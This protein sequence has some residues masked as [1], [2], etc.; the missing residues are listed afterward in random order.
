VSPDDAR[1]SGEERQSR[2]DFSGAAEAFESGG[3]FYEAAL[4]FERCDAPARCFENLLRVVPGHPRYRDACVR[5]VKLA[6]ARGPLSLGFENLVAA[7]VKSG[8]E[9][10]AEVEAFLGLAQLY[11][12]EGFTENAIEALQRISAREPGHELARRQLE[13]LRVAPPPLPELP[14]PPSP[15]RERVDTPYG[16]F[17]PLEEH[18]STPFRVGATVAGRYQ[19]EERIGAGG[20][21]VVFRARDLQLHDQVALK[22]FKQAAL[23]AES[24]ARLRRELSL[25]RLLVH[26]NVVQLYAIGL[27]FG[28][29]YVTLELLTGSDL[30]DRM[31]GEALPLGEGLDYLVQACAGLAAAHDVGIVHRDVKPENCFITRD[32][33]VKLMDF[34][35]AKA[36]D[37]SGLTAT[38]MV[39]GTPAYMA[40]EQVLNFSSVTAAA[41]QY[42]LG[43]VAYEMFTA[44]RPFR[45]PEPV[46]LMMLHTTEP[47]PP[48]RGVNPALPLEL[49]QIILRCLAKDPKQRFAS[50]RELQR[51]LELLRSRL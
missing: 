41:D 11:E 44:T 10:P 20:M 37:V 19:L 33:R 22:V 51:E 24:D 31:R 36:R 29:R 15:A 8:P 43:V 45:H 40:P 6:P 35:I 17:Q 26:P 34:G 30:A 21:S 5:A 16:R 39:A 9:L 1:R 25:S 7:F 47:P 32:A 23:D 28:M 3:H 18:E 38:G 49:E 48:P 12:R 4:A 14:E 50:C 42:S 27:A 13:R 46:P 2:G